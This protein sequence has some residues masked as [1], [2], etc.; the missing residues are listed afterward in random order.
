MRT[1]EQDGLLTACNKIIRGNP[2]ACGLI[3]LTGQILEVSKM[4]QGVS[5]WPLS[6]NAHTLKRI[7]RHYP[8]KK[9]LMFRTFTHTHTNMI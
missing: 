9:T 5:I 8:P 4:C 7:Q 3:V 6:L 1:A 2:A